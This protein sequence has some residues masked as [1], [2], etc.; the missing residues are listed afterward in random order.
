MESRLT[1]AELLKV[2]FSLQPN[3]N[4]YKENNS[5]Q[6]LVTVCNKQGLDSSRSEQGPVVGYCIQSN[7][8]LGFITYTSF[9]IA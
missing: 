1:A 6:D 8:L 4:S 9:L 5:G 2:G 7:E 3:P